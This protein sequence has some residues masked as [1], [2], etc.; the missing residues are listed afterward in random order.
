MSTRTPA[1]DTTARRPRRANDRPVW[2]E[3][4]SPAGRLGKGVTLVI[5]VLLVVFPFLIVI[6]SSLSGQAELTRNGGFV[7]IPTQPTLDAYRAVLSGGIVSRAVLVSVGVTVVGTVLSLIVTVL[8]AYALSRRGTFA[9]RPLLAVVLLTFLFTPGIIPSYLL[10]KQVGLL[11]S[12]ASLILP[13][14]ISAFNVVIIRGFFMGLPQ[15]L[16]DSARIDGASE[17][18]TLTRIVLPLSKAV[19]AVVGLFY[20][21]AYWNSF[22]SA[23]LYLDDASKWPLQLVLRAY[24]LQGSPLTGLDSGGGPPPPQQAVQMAVVVIAV[25]PIVCV[26]P[27]LQRHFTKGVLTGAVKG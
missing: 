22:F 8:T 15:E 4:P 19:I 11:D 16:I 23:L 21:V 9:Q 17:W 3:E 20:A 2:M 5:V 14:A 6:S 1:R 24:V 26:Y 12:Y 18:Q 13:T 7:L 27:F 25:I 10:V